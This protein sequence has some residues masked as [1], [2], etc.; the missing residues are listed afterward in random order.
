MKLHHHLQPFSCLLLVPLISAANFAGEDDRDIADQDI[1]DAVEWE[2]AMARHVPS[3]ELDVSCSEGVV[4]LSGEAPHLLGEQRALRIAKM[5][6]GVRSVVDRIA[7]EDTGI[8]DD[9]VKKSVT[10]ALIMDPATSSWQVVADVADGVVTLTGD[11]DSFAEK[12]LAGKVAQGV[13]GVRELRNDLDVSYSSDRLDSEIQAEIEKRLLWD[14]RIED[15]FIDVSVENGEVTLTGSVGS[16]YEEDLARADAWVAGVTDVDASA[17]EVKWWAGDP[18][19]REERGATLTEE[20]VE[21]A[22]EDAMLYDPRVNSFRPNVSVTGRT[23]TLTGEV[24]DLKAKRA[25]AQDA[26]NTVGVWRVRNLLKVRAGTPVSD[27]D[28]AANVKETLLDDPLLDRHEVTVSAVDG[29]AYL[30]GTVDSY[31]EQAHAEDLATR[32]KGVTDVANY[33][34][35]DYEVPYHSYGYYDW[36][37]M[38]YDYDYDYPTVYR[39]PDWEIVED[40]ESQLWWSPFVDADQ[41]TVTVEDGVATLTGTVDSWS[42]KDAAVENAIEGGAYKVRNELEIDYGL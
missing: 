27:A 2:L 38:L 20:Q 5:V 9:A 39:K 24:E 17:L 7:V 19:L 37:P 42:E 4:V 32:V 6:K 28:I 31:F 18:M 3:N 36:D 41:V 26:R 22:V 11:V 1:V 21:D 30:Y 13:R 40:V 10:S 23:V 25:A 29:T 16:S 8:A 12:E 15:Y 33:L 35:V 14:T 34:A